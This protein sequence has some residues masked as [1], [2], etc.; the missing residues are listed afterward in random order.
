MTRTVG[1][2]ASNCSFWAKSRYDVVKLISDPGVYICIECIGL[3]NEILAEELKS[4]RAGPAA[5]GPVR[6]IRCLAMPGGT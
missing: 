2:G 4:G 6:A 5:L 3:C 1:D